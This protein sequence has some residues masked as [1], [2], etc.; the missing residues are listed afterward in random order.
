MFYGAIREA[1]GDLVQWGCGSTICGSDLGDTWDSRAAGHA[2]PG[3][4]GRSEVIMTS[5]TQPCADAAEAW[6]LS[7]SCGAGGT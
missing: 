1:V 3:I 5:L 6:P 4:S 7:G 2:P